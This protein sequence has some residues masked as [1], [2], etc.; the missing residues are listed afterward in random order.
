M[1]VL[2]DIFKQKKANYYF[3]K[4]WVVV[5]N[6]QHELKQQ[7]KNESSKN[8]KNS[9]IEEMNS[10]IVYSAK[11]DSGKLNLIEIMA[12]EDL[13]DGGHNYKI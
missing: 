5:K 11:F 13:H 8:F 9:N 10:E 2:K 3:S 12:T 7:P 1:I 4:L 6:H